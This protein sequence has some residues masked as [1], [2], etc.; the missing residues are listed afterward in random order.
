ML[1]QYNTDGSVAQSVVFSTQF[2]GIR[3]ASAG[4]FLYAMADRIAFYSVTADKWCEVSLSGSILGMWPGVGSSKD[5]QVPGVAL[6][7]AGDVFVTAAPKRP[8]P[9]VAAAPRVSGVHLRQITLYHLD[10]SKGAWVPADTTSWSNRLPVILGMDND[11][12]VLLPND[13]GIAWAT[14]Q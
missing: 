11:K 4:A 1:R 9:A 12:L 13:G 8:D 2:P 14:I 3:D 6:T 5:L 10:K 7:A